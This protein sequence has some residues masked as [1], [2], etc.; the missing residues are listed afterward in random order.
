MRL[1]RSTVFAPLFFLACGGGQPPLDADVAAIQTLIDR[2]T[3][4]NN[5]GDITGWV[6]LFAD[7]M[8]YMPDGG[9]PVTTRD[10]LEGA[11]VS[12]FSRYR[13]NL[14]S[15]TEEIQ[16]LGDWA[17]ARTTVSGTLTPRGGNPIRV[18]RKEMAIYRRQPDGSW[19]VARLIGNSSR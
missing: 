7:D 5:A 12:H 4:V 19:K 6:E 1:L 14:Q 15:S 10:A 9:P 17:F 16:V 8:V 18:D 3:D 11:A 2:A 13:P